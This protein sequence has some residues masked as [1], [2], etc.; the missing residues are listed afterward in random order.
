MGTYSKAFVNIESIE[1]VKLAIAKYYNIISEEYDIYEQDWKFGVNGNDTIILTKEF[2]SDWVAIQ[3][4]YIFSIYYHDEML[5]RISR[6]L[7]T[8]ILYGY[9]Q[10]TDGTGRLSRFHN[11]DLEVSIIQKEAGY[12][13]ES[14]MRLVDNWGVTNKLK[15]SFNIPEINEKYFEIEWDIIYKFYKMNGLEWDKIEREDESYLHIEIK[16]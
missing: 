2:N 4:N 1:V 5:R 10:S 15:D 13:E 7:N 8:M 11:G 16:H 12:K 9:Y 3:L 6:D 14:M